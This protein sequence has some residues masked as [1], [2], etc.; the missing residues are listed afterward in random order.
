[1]DAPVPSQFLISLVRIC[2]LEVTL[3]DPIRQL[4]GKPVSRLYF[5]ARLQIW[6]QCMCVGVEM[7]GQK[8]LWVPCSPVWAPAVVNAMKAVLES[9]ASS[10]G[11]WDS[12]IY[13]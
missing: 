1:M 11:E 13:Q 10:M 3:P 7:G 5:M 8:T 12:Q 2:S 9:I 4:L 6:K